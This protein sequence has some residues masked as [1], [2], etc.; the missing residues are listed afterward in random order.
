MSLGKLPALILQLISLGFYLPGMLILGYSV[1]IW[2]SWLISALYKPIIV[3]EVKLGFVS[4]QKYSYLNNP[5]IILST[6]S[7]LSDFLSLKISPVASFA[8]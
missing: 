6:R 2:I 4:S 5:S 1:S 8:K 3:I 7:S